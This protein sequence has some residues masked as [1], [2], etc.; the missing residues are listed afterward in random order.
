MCIDDWK[1]KVGLLNKILYTHSNN[2]T[3]FLALLSAFFRLAFIIAD[4]GNPSQFIFLLLNYW[5]SPWHDG[6]LSSFWMQ[7]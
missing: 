4:N 5:L 2:W 3:K 7:Q 1:I 6:G